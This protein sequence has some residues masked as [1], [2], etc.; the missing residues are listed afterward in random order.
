[1]PLGAGLVHATL[2]G[3][4]QSLTDVGVG[5]A[6]FLLCGF[7]PFMKLRDLRAATRGELTLGC[8][9]ACMRAIGNIVQLLVW[10]EERE[11]QGGHEQ[12]QDKGWVQQ[13]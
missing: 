13:D 6:Y 5:Q 10:A 4:R 2:S 9:C 12:I 11:I 1:M 7:P 8:H 3:M